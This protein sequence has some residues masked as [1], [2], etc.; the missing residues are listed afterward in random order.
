MKQAGL[1]LPFG[2][3][4]SVAAQVASPAQLAAL[5]QYCPACSELASTISIKAKPA[6]S[7]K[8]KTTSFVGRI[9]IVGYET[10]GF[11]AG[12]FQQPWHENCPPA[13]HPEAG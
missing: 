6:D 8:W 10:T 13:V 1:P 3:T 4:V 7:S 2:V 9:D 12:G 5:Q 11:L